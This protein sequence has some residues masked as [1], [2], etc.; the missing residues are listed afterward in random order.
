MGVKYTLC[1]RV[2]MCVYIVVMFIDR[3]NRKSEIPYFRGYV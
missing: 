2:S 3:C 1:I